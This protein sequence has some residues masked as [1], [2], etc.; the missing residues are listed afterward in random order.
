MTMGDL[1]MPTTTRRVA[2]LAAPSPALGWERVGVRT[3]LLAFLLLGACAP[4]YEP[5]VSAR[6]RAQCEYDAR[7]ATAGT[8]NA[9]QQSWEQQDLLRRCLALAEADSIDN[10][11]IPPG[12]EPLPPVIVNP[13]IRE[14][15]GGPLGHRR[16]GRFVPLDPQPASPVR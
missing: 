10:K 2:C 1:P 14:V 15:P 16:N 7:R 11:V 12:A 5:N 6:Q 3:C 13:P 9:F 4:G 8:A